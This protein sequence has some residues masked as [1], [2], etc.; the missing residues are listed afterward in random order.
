V[1]SNFEVLKSKVK[2]TIFGKKVKE[3]L[4]QGSERI[5]IVSYNGK[6][7]KYSIRFV[8]LPKYFHSDN[9]GIQIVLGLGMVTC[10]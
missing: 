3:T 4:L 6:M 2:I 10:L 1:C 5:T 7:S 8:I 9:N